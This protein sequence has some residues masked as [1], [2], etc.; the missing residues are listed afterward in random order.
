M[1]LL[2]ITPIFMFWN[3]QKPPPQDFLKL[4]KKSK[5]SLVSFWYHDEIKRPKSVDIL[6]L[7]LKVS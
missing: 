3:P 1:Y 2:L 5:T 6:R 4:F 7:F